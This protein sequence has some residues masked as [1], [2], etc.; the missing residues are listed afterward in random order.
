MCKVLKISRITYY[1]QFYWVASNRTLETRELDEAIQVI[2]HNNKKRYGAP[3][4]H[5]LPESEGW[6]VSL[7]GV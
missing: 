6:H 2:F 4:I 1:K 5:K 3:K 7:K